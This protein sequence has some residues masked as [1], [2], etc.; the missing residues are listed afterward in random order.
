[1]CAMVCQFGAISAHTSRRTALKCDGCPDRLTIGLRPACVDACPTRALEFG[2]EEDLVSE[3]RLSTAARV[4][5]AVS[6][7]AVAHDSAAT[8]LDTLRSLRGC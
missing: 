6:G 2:E 4:A 7:S 5:Q 3:K 8:P 1:M